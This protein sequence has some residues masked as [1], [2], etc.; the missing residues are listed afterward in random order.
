MSL[1]ITYEEFQRRV[2]ASLDQKIKWSKQRIVEWYEAFN[3][4]VYVAVS[5]GKDSQVL[6]DMV[7]DLYPDVPGVHCFTGVEFPEVL[8][9]VREMK[10]VEILK[11]RYTFAQI[12]ERCGYPVISKD[13]AKKVREARTSKHDSTI[14]RRRL[15]GI[16]SDGTYSHWA[17]I[18]DKWQF[19]CN[20]PFDIGAG[21]C[22]HLKKN[23]A[24]K[25]E[26]KTGRAPMLG[27]MATEGKA[28]E[29]FY[30]KFGCNAF[31]INQPRSTP[32]AFWTDDDIWEYIAR[33][34]LKP[35]S[36]YSMGYARTGCLYCMFGIHLDS[37]PNRFERLKQTHPKHYRYAMEDLGLRQV[38]EY[39]RVSHGGKPTNIFDAPRVFPGKN[40]WIGSKT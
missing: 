35:A 18:A 3:G 34:N 19:L 6:I 30:F 9:V 8:R 11:P 23:P 15:T 1:L 5:G 40:L 38:L 25:Y 36:V 17:K 27:T 4:N 32:L 39:L 16:K 33:R 31:D 20:A 12:I 37:S 14:R 2:N 10:D 28:R 13:I 21:C 7:R 22:K 29:K 26:K 24:H